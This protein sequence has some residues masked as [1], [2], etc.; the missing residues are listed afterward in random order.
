[1]RIALVRPLSRSP[2]YDPE[3]QEPLGNE[4]L[5]S[6]LRRSSH[7]VLLCDAMLSSH[8]EE[9]LARK[10]VQFDPKVVGLSLMS[11]ADIESANWLIRYIKAPTCSGV[12]FVVGGSFISTEPERVA[13]LLPE[14]TLLIRYEGEGPLLKTLE[15]IGGAVSM[16]DV[17]SLLWLRDGRLQGSPSFELTDNLDSLPWPARD[18]AEEVLA[19][20]GVMNIQ[21]SRG[22]TGSCAYCCMPGMPRP[23]GQ[24]WRGRSPENIVE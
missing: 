20:G 14:G 7:E 21:G 4:L 16:Q 11:D 8:A 1:M 24:P 6:V 23:S 15:A 18:S 17:S 3:I 12:V 2:D 13:S 10:I 19:R 5:A 9:H 22:C